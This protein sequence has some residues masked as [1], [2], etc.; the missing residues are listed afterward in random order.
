MKETV[1]QLY[2]D[3]EEV[4]RMEARIDPDGNGY[5]SLEDWMTLMTHKF[6]NRE[7]DLIASF[8]VFDID[9]ISYVDKNELKIAF[10]DFM[11]SKKAE[12]NDRLCNSIF[13]EIANFTND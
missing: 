10:M 2:E 11:D 9:D 13:N 5:Y 1:F 4:I 6:N 7:E 8:K 12:E 3:P